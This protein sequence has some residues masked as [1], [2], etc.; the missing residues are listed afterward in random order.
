VGLLAD[1]PL[2]QP[3]IQFGQ[4]RLGGVDERQQR[5]S[6]AKPAPCAQ[7]DGGDEQQGRHQGDHDGKFNGVQA[8]TSAAKQHISE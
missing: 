2:R 3:R 8:R 6:A 4:P 7:R 5:P 1:L